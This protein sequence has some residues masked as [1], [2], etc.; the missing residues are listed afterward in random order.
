MRR[1]SIYK[2]KNVLYLTYCAKCGKQG[3]GSTVCWKPR[4]SNHKSHI[5]QFVYSCKIVKHFIEICN[6]PI[7]PHKCL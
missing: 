3:V 2:T 5:K 1:N 7:V 6:D 4:I